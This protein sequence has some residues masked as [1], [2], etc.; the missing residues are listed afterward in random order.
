M[1]VLITLAVSSVPALAH[2]TL[3]RSEPV[4]GSVVASTPERF[5]LIFSE[6]VS[7]L[8][9]KLIDPGGES[10]ALTDYRVEGEEVGV[11]VPSL[12][13]GTHVLSWRVVSAD[14]HP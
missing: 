4:D 8:V 9:L 12:G 3:I 5:T 13:E 1:V 14:G 2:A 7:P 11:A 6:P 10:R